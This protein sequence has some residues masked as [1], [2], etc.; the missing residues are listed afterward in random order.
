MNQ[1]F[2]TFP[3]ELLTSGEEL[4]LVKGGLVSQQY[5]KAAYFYLLLEGKVKVYI[6]IDEKPRPL[7]VGSL[8]APLTPLGWSGLNLPNRYTSTIK[9]V[10]KSARVMRF[11]RHTLENT[12][13]GTATGLHFYKWLNLETRKLIEDAAGFFSADY[14]PKKERWI[15]SPES[16]LLDSSEAMGLLCRSPFFE[17]FEESFLD[18]LSK[19]ARKFLYGAGQTVYQQGACSDGLIMLSRGQ[20]DYYVSD[21]NDR[22]VSM[23]SISNPGY[24]IGWSAVLEKENIMTAVAR[25]PTE[26]LLIPRTSVVEV[27]NA[28]PKIALRFHKRILWLITHQLQALRARM[29]MKKYDQ[30]WL[31]IQSLIEQNASRLHL[32][33]SL[34]KL[35]LLL[36]NPLT[37]TEAFNMLEQVKTHGSAQEKYIATSSLEIL[38]ETH[39]EHRFYQ[40]L[41]GVYQTVSNQPPNVSAI[42]TRKKCAEGMISAFRFARVEIRGW[43][44]LPDH[45]GHIFIYNHL[46]NHDYNTL[47]NK[48]QITLDSH[49]ISAN[50]LYQKYG[51]PGLRIVRI[52]R[53]SEYGHQDYYDRL[54]HI[55]VFTP[56]SDVEGLSPEQKEATRRAF[57][58]TAA[59][60]LQ[61]KRNL[62]ISPEGTSYHTE[63]SPGPFR[64]GAFNLAL[65]LDP[66]PYIIPVVMLNFDRR[67]RYNTFRCEI[68]RPFKMSDRLTKKH[69]K[70][71]MS[72]FLQ[73]YQQQF[74]QSIEDAIYTF[75]KFQSNIATA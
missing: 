69:S 45:S 2:G 53:G 58:E 47:P 73:N 64:P 56:E 37:L 3:K 70:Q 71:D 16:L 19:H 10:S 12:L 65:N 30:E 5:A 44:N 20:V 48:F 25:Q 72:N 6:T 22:E 61:A 49:F 74:R 63:E 21:N 59:Q 26:L 40:A 27:L 57:F 29:V 4:T 33:S 54:G 11:H 36:R 38:Q 39:N 31:S 13:A 75:E 17:V 32:H 1:D 35:P 66:E 9:V 8:T 7:L 43:E 60:E 15:A 14:L 23:R 67:V 41:M 52:G 51:D 42:Q 18:E 50:I 46:K 34:Y 28:H 68:Q 62:I 55:N 24:I